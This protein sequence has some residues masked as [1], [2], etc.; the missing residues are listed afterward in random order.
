MSSMTETPDLGAHTAASSSSPPNSTPSPSTSSATTANSASAS[1][2]APR[3][4]TLTQQ[5]KNNKRQRATQDQLVTL[6]VEFNKNPTPTAATRERIASDINM[7]ERSVQIWFQNRRAKIK[8]LAKKSIETGEGCDSIPE[9]MR[10]YLAMQFDPTKPGTRDPFGRSAGYGGA[11]SM[12]ANETNPSGKVV[13]SH[14]TCRSLTIGNWRRIGQNA[15]DLVVFYSPD[16]ACMTYYINN[17]SA[18]YKIEYPFAHIKNITLETGDPNPGPNGAPPRPGGLVV[19]LNR[20]PMFYMDSSNSGGFYQ[21]GDFT[22]EQQASQIMVHHLGGH[23]KV[24]SVQLAKLVSLESF[25]NRLAYNGNNSFAVPAPPAAPTAMSP[26]FIQRPASQ[27]NHYAAPTP[28]LGLYQDNG[29]LGFNMPAAARGHKRQR[30][31]SVPAAV[32][33]SALQAPMPPFHMPQTPA[34]FNHTDHGIYAPVPQSAHGHALPTDLRIETEGYGLD[35]RPNPMSA[36][37]AASPSDFASPSMFSSAAQGESTP[38]AS[39]PPQF[40]V[41]YVSGGGPSDTSTVGSHAPSPYSGVSPAD[42]MIANHSPPLSNMSHASSDMYGFAHDQQSGFVEDGLSMN[43]MY[44]KH[45]VNYT[46][47]HDAPS[48]ELPMHGMPGH[49]S[50]A[51]GDY[52]HGMVNLDE[53]NSQGLPTGS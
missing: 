51:L 30:S 45:N 31:R 48:F 43:D 36:T 5:Q 47:S 16:K 14:F 22:E 38:V 18:G 10:H 25:Q 35:F 17:D 29:H 32:D 41:S 3:K 44:P 53:I 4:S 50:P 28:Y 11:P 37:T 21:C 19:E 24:L 7:T 23:P 15:M 26:P 2:R 49:A 20:P 13:I 34:P 46:V 42:P 8:M 27:P 1:R 52:S 40:N 33:I 6:E 12:Y 39:M 9:S